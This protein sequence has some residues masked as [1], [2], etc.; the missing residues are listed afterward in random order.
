MW[1]TKL[2]VSFF[3]RNELFVGRENQRPEDYRK[4]KR[5]DHMIQQSKRCC[6]LLQQ[7]IPPQVLL[8]NPIVLFDGFRKCFTF[9]LNWI[10]SLNVGHSL[11]NSLLFNPLT[12][13][14]PSATLWQ[15]KPGKC[16]K[17]GSKRKDMPKFGKAI[18]CFK[19]SINSI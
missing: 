4:R 17:I 19:I 15:G 5:Q 10:S 14:S 3:P 18:S 11:K 7:N 13:D 8:E 16:S 12:S 9:S 6:Q 2:P 1:L